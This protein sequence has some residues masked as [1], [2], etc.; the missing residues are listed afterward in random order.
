[1]NKA[2]RYVSGTY[3]Q[4]DFEFMPAPAGGMSSNARDMAYFMMN[5]LNGGSFEDEQILK[6]KTVEQMF[7]QQFTQHP[8]LNG[9][10]LGFIEGH[11]N[12]KRTLFHNGSTM[13]FDAG[14]YLVPEEHV[15]IFIAYSGADHLVHLDIFNDF[16]DAYFPVKQTSPP[17]QAEDAAERSQAYVG[18][19]HQNRKSFTTDEKIISLTM[20]TSQVDVDDEDYLTVIHFGETHRFLEVE[21]GMYENIAQTHTNDPF[22]GFRTIA[23]DQDAAGNTLLM[24]DGPMT[25][26]KAP[27]YST[28]AFTFSTLIISILFILITLICWGTAY[29]IRKFSGKT[30]LRSRLV[31]TL[32]SFIIIYGLLTIGV[33]AGL[34]ISGQVD[35]VYRLPQA[36]YA[37]GSKFQPIIDVIPLLMTVVGIAIIC[38]TIICWIKRFGKLSQR[39]HFSLFSTVALFFIWVFVFWNLF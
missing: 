19:Y 27:W 9:M 21:D 10:G 2:Y 39:I 8:H 34:A 12:D 7:S 16:M 26:S 13:L 18:E 28:T 17:A 3:Q 4:T 23:F 11:F 5:Y 25:Y 29:L 6:N 1:M 30:I 36:A 20:G 24:T 31:V 14:F 37:H 35:P 32:R 22:G 38:L 15:G 33:I